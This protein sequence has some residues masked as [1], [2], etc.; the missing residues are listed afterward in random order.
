[1]KNEKETKA[2]DE[3]GLKTPPPRE[4]TTARGRLFEFGK[5]AL[6]HRKLITK[7][8]KFLSMGSI[9]Y[10]SLVTC[11]KKR[12]I[13]VEDFTKLKETELT[14]EELEVITNMDT[15]AKKA[16]FTEMMNEILA[17]VLLATLKKNVSG[18]MVP[19]FESIDDLEIEMD[20]YGEAV[21]LFPI[22]TK[23]VAIASNEGNANRKN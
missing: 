3:Y 13:S 9:D 19:R 10:D 4:Y 16:E 6:R 5:P 15:P 8:L 20:D 17:E 21:E 11:A 18:K 12:K 2:T 23:W 1:M 22:A 7:V 14:K